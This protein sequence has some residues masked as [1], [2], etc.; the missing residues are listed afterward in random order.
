MYTSCDV[1][2]N[3]ILSPYIRP[4]TQIFH[5]NMAL[6][7]NFKAWVQLVLTFFEFGAF[8]ESDRCKSATAMIDDHYL[9]E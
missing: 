6:P 7:D 4:I 3:T 8:G 2:S 9:V 1:I 5:A